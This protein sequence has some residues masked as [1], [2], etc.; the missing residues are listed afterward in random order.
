[1]ALE[2]RQPRWI[3]PAI[4][5]PGQA[6]PVIV[7]CPPGACVEAALSWAGERTALEVSASRPCAD[8]RHVTVTCRAAHDTPPRLYALR[9]SADG[10]GAVSP[11]AVCVV[12][13]FA[14]PLMFV[15]I[16]DLH[17]PSMSVDG[18]LQDRATVLKRL[19]R[20][21]NEIR[22]ALVINTGDLV[23]R[24]GQDS[25]EVLSPEVVREQT[26]LAREALLGLEV[27]MFLTPGNHDVAFPWSRQAWAEQMGTPWIEGTEDYSFDYG[28]CHFACLDASVRYDPLTA[29]I[30]RDGF[31]AEQLS[32]LAND[33]RAAASKRLRFLFFHYDYRQ[34]LAPLLAPLRVNVALYG[35]ATYALYGELSAD[36]F[37]DAHLPPARAYQVAR[38]ADGEVSV[39]SGLRYLQMQ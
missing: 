15:H 37:C 25:G 7:L 29:K 11:N 23:N 30:E 28:D 16:S 2:I 34:Q 10:E 39:E 12:E 19:V 5:Q 35:H 13:R 9:A 3:R 17:L 6:F 1:M 31:T 22:P 27:P 14:D 21:I 24:Y 32:W 36:D 4:V 8:G 20:V 26:R 18:I 33:M 38:A